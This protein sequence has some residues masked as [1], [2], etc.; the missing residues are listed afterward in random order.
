MEED[1]SSL[2]GF[3]RE[4]MAIFHPTCGGFRVLGL[5]CNMEKG[6]RIGNSGF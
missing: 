3:F 5:F 4:S 6:G 2:L 1:E